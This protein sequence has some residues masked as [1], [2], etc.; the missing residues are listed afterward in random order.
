MTVCASSVLKFPERQCNY[1]FGL[2]HCVAAPTTSL[3]GHGTQPTP[4]ATPSSMPHPVPP[5]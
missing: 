5:A 3:P 2:P 4:C 1:I